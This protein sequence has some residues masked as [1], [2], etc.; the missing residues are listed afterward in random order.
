MPAPHHVQVATLERFVDAWKRWSAE[1]MIAEFADDFTQATLPFGMGI[2]ERQKSAVQQVL[3]VLVG[4][5]SDYKVR[6]I[7][8]SNI[9]ERAE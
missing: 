6:T 8:T 9:H 2:P 4:T 1:D 3:P 7:Y 5:V